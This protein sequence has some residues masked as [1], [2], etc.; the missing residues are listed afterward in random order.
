MKTI[1]LTGGGT[2]GHIYPALS[3]AKEVKKRYPHV[4]IAFIGTK[5]GLESKI[6]SREKDIEFHIIDIQGFKRKVSW[7]N[8]QT[9][10]KFM[11]AVR[12]SKEIIKELQPDVVIGTGGYVSGPPVYSAYRLGIPTL[13]HE[14]N[15][16]PG[17][18][19]KFLSRFVSTVAVSFEQSIKYFQKKCRVIYA[20]N[21]RA[22]DVVRANAAAGRELLGVKDERKKIVLLFGGSQG[23][24]VINNAVLAMLPYFGQL[25]QVQFV[26][27]TGEAHYEKIRERIQTEKYS[28]L[29]I[30]SFIYNMPDVLAAAH[31]VIGR[32]GASTLAEL[33]AL[34]LPSILIPSPYVTNNHQVLNARWLEQHNA[35]KMIEEK[36]CTGHELWLAICELMKNNNKL[37]Q[38]SNA[39]RELGFPEA[40]E[41]IV[42]QLEKLIEMGDGHTIS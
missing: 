5:N 41:F 42:N 20:G 40:A 13:I 30:K 14:Q 27:V 23:A 8:I 18:T 22:T 1:L 35:C 11:R 32:A 17:L 28:N 2:G 16:V 29:Y 7:T 4:R 12:K 3:I 25:P 6:V 19:T 38:M 36:A 10:I 39:S 31:L 21:P 24:R 15:V 34:G 26:Y 37:A 9:V 33:T